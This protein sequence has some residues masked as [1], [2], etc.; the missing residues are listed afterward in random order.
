MTKYINVT[1]LTTVIPAAN[2]VWQ[3]ANTQQ[4]SIPTDLAPLTFDQEL[5]PVAVLQ[6]L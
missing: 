2:A 6:K 3:A 5:T 1:D 4:V